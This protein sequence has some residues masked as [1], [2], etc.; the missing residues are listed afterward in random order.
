MLQW[1]PRYLCTKRRD[2]AEVPEE[3][4]WKQ[5]EGTRGLLGRLQMGVLVAE[6]RL[7]M[8]EE[9]SNDYF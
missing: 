3:S 7:L 1:L 6:K 2:S 4:E 5:Q 8:K 9:K